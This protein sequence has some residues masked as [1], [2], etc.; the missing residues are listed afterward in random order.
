[1]R[2]IDPGFR[3]GCKIIV[4]DENGTVVAS[5]RQVN[6]NAQIWF[7]AWDE[8]LG[9]KLQV[10]GLRV[11]ERATMRFESPDVMARP[12]SREFWTHRL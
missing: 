9:F 11:M 12:P 2:P 8:L 10:P 4:L 3:T 1:M 5:D 7:A 6:D